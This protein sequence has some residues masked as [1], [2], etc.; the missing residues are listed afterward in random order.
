MMPVP[1]NCPQRAFVLADFVWLRSKVGRRP[2]QS[3]PQVPE[4]VFRFGQATIA[5]DDLKAP[6]KTRVIRTI[7]QGRNVGISQ[8][9]YGDCL[10]SLGIETRNDRNRLAD[11]VSRSLGLRPIGSTEIMRPQSR[12]TVFWEGYRLSVRIARTVVNP[13]RA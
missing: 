5:P 8:T 3:D 6:A 10:K 12:L 13:R 1:K 2:P 7:A 11:I 9:W 4:P